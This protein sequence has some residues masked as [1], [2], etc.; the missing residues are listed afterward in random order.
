[1]YFLLYLFTVL[2][3]FFLSFF[4]SV[5]SYNIL[6]YHLVLS[7]LI[8]SDHIIIYLCILAIHLIY[9]SYPYIHLIFPCLHLSSIRLS[10][11]IKSN[12]IFPNLRTSFYVSIMCQSVF[13]SSIV[14]LYLY[15]MH[16]HAVL[17]LQDRY[18]LRDIQIRLFRNKKRQKT[19]GNDTS[20][21]HVRTTNQFGQDFAKDLHG[22]GSS[23]FRFL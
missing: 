5:L 12:H 9:R 3:S 11:P 14:H 1:M 22:F 16:S 20:E 18:S 10:I 21:A 4:L 15:L 23:C 13:C 2:F 8:S 6:Q 19:S 17:L 7:Y